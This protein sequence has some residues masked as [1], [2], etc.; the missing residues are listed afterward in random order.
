MSVLRWFHDDA[1]F[2]AGTWTCASDDT[3]PGAVE[4]SSRPALA[5]T[6]SGAYRRHVGSRER[7]VDTG[8]VV[9]YPQWMEYRVS[10]PVPGGD[11][12][13]VL[14]LTGEGLAS[15]GIEGLV[16]RGAALPKRSTLVM[17]Q[18]EMAARDEAALAVEE[19]LLDLASRAWRRLS[20]TPS[21]SPLPGPTA[22]A[23]ERAIRRAKE[24]MA[25]RYGERLTLDDIARD[26]GYSVPHLCEIFRRGTGFTIHRYLSRLRL[27]TAL[28]GLADHESLTRLAY[29]V[30]FSTPS[31]FSTAFRR[32]FGHPPSRLLP[33]LRT[34]DV[35]RLRS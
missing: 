9:S 20:R 33:V 27:L 13:L 17:K 8:T 14:A 29:E 15:L 5:F 30:G 16:E 6:R 7:L 21:P 28:E 35:A 2:Q 12:S 25:I 34:E 22:A 32:E 19:L 11:R 24:S 3:A 23:H 18:V 26:A 4:A 10:H 31:H 1:R